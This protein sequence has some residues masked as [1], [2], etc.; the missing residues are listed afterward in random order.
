MP[1]GL[2]TAPS[3]FQR[4]I[5]VTLQHL[6][7]VCLPYIDDILVRARSRAELRQRESSVLKA[8]RGAAMEVAMDKSETQ[9][10]EIVFCG[11]QITPE[12]VSATPLI[13][14]LADLPIPYSLKDRQ[15][16]LGFMNYFRDYIID[17][18][19]K[20]EP[21]YPNNKNI[22]RSDQYEKDYRTLINACLSHVSLSHYRDGVPAE[23]YTDASLYAGGAILVQQSKVIAI[24][25]AKFSP[26]QTRYSATD[27]EHL[28]LLLAVEKFK[29]FTQSNSA[30][31]LCT[32]HRSLL[33]RDD[34][35]LTPRQCRWKQR[36]L[37][38]VGQ[39]AWIPGL[40]NPADF[41]SRQGS[42]FVIGGPFKTI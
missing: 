19:A 4:H 3:F 25:S 11:I 8:L 9:R 26:A 33:N 1:F 28:A 6:R 13:S 12:G 22:A 40:T 27:R 2:K 29:V 20:A 32:D 18:A 21:L 5:D 30:L 15:S 10:Q 35:K 36:I 14:K 16:A 23:L 41:M 17:F 7:E 24:W 37:A 39:I 31:S 38:C 42:G 34:D